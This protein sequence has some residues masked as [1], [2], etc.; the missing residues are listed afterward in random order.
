MLMQTIVRTAGIYTT[1]FKYASSISV[2]FESTSDSRMDDPTYTSFDKKRLTRDAVRLLEQSSVYDAAR[3]MVDAVCE[4][5]DEVPQMLSEDLGADVVEKWFRH[6]VDKEANNNLLLDLDQW[7]FAT[8]L[9]PLDAL[10][11]AGEKGGCPEEHKNTAAAWVMSC[12][13]SADEFVDYSK[14]VK[15]NKD[16]AE[17]VY[18]CFSHMLKQHQAFDWLEKCFVCRLDP[19]IT[20]RK[21]DEY[22]K[23]TSA[24]VVPILLQKE[25]GKCILVYKSSQTQKLCQTSFGTPFE[26]VA[27]WLCCV[28]EHLAGVYGRKKRVLDII[29]RLKRAS[30][31]ARGNDESNAVFG[32]ATTQIDV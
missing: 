6:C 31:D 32:G 29:E 25:A 9:S 17:N 11:A 5:F 8:F 16:F 28:R 7:G 4:D 3:C 15:D 30:K 13:V 20:L 23:Q 2:V 24:T 26:G 1:A 12:K 14:R 27:G 18:L 10:V 21:L 22:R 19:L